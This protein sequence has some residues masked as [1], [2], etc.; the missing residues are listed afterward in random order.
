M[1]LLTSQSILDCTSEEQEEQHQNEIM[2]ILDKIYCLPNYH[3]ALQYR[4]IDKLHEDKEETIKG[5][6]LHEFMEELDDIDAK[7]GID[8]A[9]QKN[10]VLTLVAYGQNY[11]INNK[12][13]MRETH[14]DILPMNEYREFLNIIPDIAPQQELN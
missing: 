3:T 6:L 13:Y 9:Y 14:I 5:C 7:N 2:E 11:Q 10:G 8:F 4:Y 12:W 1:I